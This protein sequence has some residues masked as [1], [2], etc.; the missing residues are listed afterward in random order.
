MYESFSMQDSNNEG[1]TSLKV[2]KDQAFQA[3]YC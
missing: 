1:I 3:Q 2:E